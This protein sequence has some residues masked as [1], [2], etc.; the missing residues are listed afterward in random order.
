MDL[1][2]QTRSAVL[3][4][5]I[6]T[7]ITGLLYPLAI[8]GIAKVAFPKQAEGSLIR[9]ADGTIVGSSLIGQNF[10]DVKYFHPRP[11]AAGNDGYDGASSSGSN[12]G[13]TSQKLID[14][15]KERAVAYRQENGLAADAM[16]PVDAVTASASGL[17][18]QITP[19]NAA[20]QIARVAKARNL[21][22]ADVRTLVAQHTEGRTLGIFGEPRVNVLELN[23]AL[24]AR[25]G[26]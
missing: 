3:M 15:V 21:P 14:Q 9:R 26:Q 24:D 19:A 12:L 25:A 20:L 4:L 6:L 1:L 13:P 7:G 22:E 10:S 2:K 5:L 11:S 23:L 8:T 18:P 16:V 17:D